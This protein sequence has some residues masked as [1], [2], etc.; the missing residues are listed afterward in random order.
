VIVANL[1]PRQLRGEVSQGM[2]LAASDLKLLAEGTA[3]SGDAKPGV[4]E[5]DVV[6]LTVAKPV[7]P[8]S[9]VS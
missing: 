1:E 3:A 4:D 9:R 5:R 2:I 6:V 8:G 7:K